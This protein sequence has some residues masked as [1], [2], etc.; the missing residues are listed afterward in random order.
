MFIVGGFLLG[1][2]SLWNGL[3]AAVWLGVQ[4]RRIVAEEALLMHDTAY[5]TYARRVPYRLFPGLW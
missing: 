1:S 4:F 2:C 3:I 5:Q